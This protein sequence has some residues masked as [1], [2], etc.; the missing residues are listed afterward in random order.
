[1]L[2]VSVLELNCCREAVLK[3]TTYSLI[4]CHRVFLMFEIS[5]VHQKK[6]NLL[7]GL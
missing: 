7:D 6:S 4:F 3:V 2:F 5:E 1:M